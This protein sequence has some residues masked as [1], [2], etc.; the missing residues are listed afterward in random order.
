MGGG[1]HCKSCI[2]VIEQ[3]NN[4]TIGGIVEKKY[5]IKSAIENYPTIGY[6]DDLPSLRRKFDYAL[7]T[8]GQILN[9]KSRI[10][11]YES[12]KELNFIIPTIISPR[13]YVS[14]C[15]F[16]EEGT[17]VMHDSLVNF[18][19]KVGKNCILNTKSLVEH[20][21]IIGD[22]CH[23][24]TGVVINGEV[25]VGSEAFVGSSSVIREKTKL[26]KNCFVAAGTTV[27]KNLTPNS[28][29]MSSTRK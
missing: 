8:V 21:A 6:N 26:G 28:K 27:Y 22:H 19:A 16:I 1:G 10:F 29:V 18:S 24:S 14:N 13:A 2:D 5:G 20:D 15:A 3:E 25:E 12:L 7:V 4:F 23:I 11:L 9:A 17:I